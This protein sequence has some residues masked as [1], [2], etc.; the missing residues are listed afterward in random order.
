MNDNAKLLLERLKGFKD[1]CDDATE[2]PWFE[3]E[4]RDGVFSPARTIPGQ[5]YIGGLLDQTNNRLA[6]SAR[7]DYPEVLEMCTRLIGYVAGLAD[8]PQGRPRLHRPLL[9]CNS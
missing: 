8:H 1:V 5:V 3:A 9:Y 2:G 4:E 7:N 6:I